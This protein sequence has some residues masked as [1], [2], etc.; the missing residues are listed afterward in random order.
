MPF[1]Q[2]LSTPWPKLVGRRPLRGLVPPYALKSALQPEPDQM[3][4][5]LQFRM[6]DEGG[7]VVQNPAVVDEVHLPRLERKLDAEVGPLEHVVEHVERSPLGGGQRLIDFFVPGF[8]PVTQV[9]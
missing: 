4:P 7:A 1:R 2:R 5:L 8:D 6:I 9:A 3:P